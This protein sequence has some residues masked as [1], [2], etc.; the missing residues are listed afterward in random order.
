MST[1]PAITR[2][3]ITT[4]RAPLPCELCPRPTARDCPHHG[5]AG[6]ELLRRLGDAALDQALG[7][8]RR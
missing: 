3:P 8:G 2:A 7:E 6:A 4:G 5:D 1:R